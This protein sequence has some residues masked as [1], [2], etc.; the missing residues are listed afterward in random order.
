MNNDTDRPSDSL[1]STHHRQAT[2]PMWSPTPHPIPGSN[3]ITS[4]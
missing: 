1:S 4:V 2:S 3:K